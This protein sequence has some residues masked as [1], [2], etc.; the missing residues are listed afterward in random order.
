MDNQRLPPIIQPRR[1]GRPPL[2]QS[3]KFKRQ[4]NLKDKVVKQEANRNSSDIR[5][6]SSEVNEVNT[7]AIEPF[8]PELDIK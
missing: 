4:N 2:S 8:L 1:R 5:V 7:V 6:V 3:E